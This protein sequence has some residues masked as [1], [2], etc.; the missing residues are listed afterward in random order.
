[1]IR[2]RLTHTK[3]GALRYTGNLDMQKVWE[4]TFRRARL[5]LTYSQGF[6]TQP[7]INQACPLPLG[8]GSD[9]EL[10]D[11]WLN[12][13]LPLEEIRSS[14][15]DALPGGVSIHKIEVVDLHAPALQTQ[16]D[17]S[18]YEIILHQEVNHAE[19]ETKVAEILSATSLPRERRG[20]MYDLR[21][22]ITSMRIIDGADQ[23][24][25]LHLT[26]TVR[27]GA[28]GRPEEVLLALGLDPFRTTITR[29]QLH[30]KPSQPIIS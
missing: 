20:K 25:I 5:P 26:T 17:T 9:V 12:E 16:V 21:P 15:E 29:T 19:L 10:L 22:L 3:I 30:L 23:S 2:I 24:L 1:M 8:F 18:E 4:R 13:P 14:I 6:H 28:T 11:F 7:R 27:E